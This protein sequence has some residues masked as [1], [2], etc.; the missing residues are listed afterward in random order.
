MMYGGTMR[1]FTAVVPL[2]SDT[3]QT[4]KNN[5]LPQLTRQTPRR[6]WPGDD[7]ECATAYVPTIT[8]R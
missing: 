7:T 3:K 4:T 2:W 6:G 1:T 5:F 8:R